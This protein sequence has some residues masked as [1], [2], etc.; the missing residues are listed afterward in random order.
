MSETSCS[1]ES[2]SSSSS[3]GRTCSVVRPCRSARRPLTRAPSSDDPVE[4]GAELCLPLEVADGWT[5]PIRSTTAQPSSG[6]TSSEVPVNPV[7]Q[8]VDS[9]HDPHVA[10][11]E[12]PAERARVGRR[13]GLTARHLGDRG[14]REDRMAF[15]RR[16]ARWRT[17]RGRR[18]ARTGPAWPATP[19][20]AQVLPSCTSPQTSPGSSRWSPSSSVAAISRRS[21]ARRPEAGA[22]EP[23]RRG[24]G[25]GERPVERRRRSGRRSPSRAAC[26]RGRCRR[27]ARERRPPASA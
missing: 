10:R 9:G 3:P 24:H 21:L 16:A 19:P 26:T 17:G 22:L 18:P 27:S 6:A 14:G 2:R 7:C 8:Y 23:E 12:P 11:V 5:P 20:S 15:G 1:T 4:L 25:L 13:A